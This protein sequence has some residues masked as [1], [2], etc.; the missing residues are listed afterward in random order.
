MLSDVKMIM[1]K[2]PKKGPIMNK[3]AL[4]TYDSYLESL[5]PRQRKKFDEGYRDFVFSE[6]LIALM[7]EDEISVRALAKEAGISPTI[8]Q[9]VRSG[10]QTNLT[11]QSFLSMMNSLGC[12]VIIK[13]GRN[14]FPINT[15][16]HRA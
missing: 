10:K 7:Q 12:S 14:Q 13:K 5:T 9:R 15:E 6:L 2:E 4:S 16:I 3:K 8:I 11:M 1:Y